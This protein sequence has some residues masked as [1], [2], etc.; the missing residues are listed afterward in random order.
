MTPDEFVEVVATVT[1]RWPDQQPW[2]EQTLQFLYGD[3]ATT[4]V[5]TVDA[6]IASFV[7]AGRQFRP[8][9]AEL[10]A[11]VAEITADQARFAPAELPGPCVEHRWAYFGVGTGAATNYGGPFRRCLVCGGEEEVQTPRYWRKVEPEDDPSQAMA[12]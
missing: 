9:P 10:H 4:P 6:A 11:R 8:S 5:V 1:A 12:P 7:E 3:L 2:P